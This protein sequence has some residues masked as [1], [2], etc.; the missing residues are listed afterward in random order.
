VVFVFFGLS[1]PCG[2]IKKMF[3]RSCLES[4]FISMYQKLQKTSSTTTF[5]KKDTEKVAQ[6]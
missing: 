2:L 3:L 1:S 4:F 6:E 5:K